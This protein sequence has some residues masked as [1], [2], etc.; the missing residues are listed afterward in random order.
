[1]ATLHT[2]TLTVTIDTPV[3]KEDAAAS[4]WPSRK[5]GTSGPLPRR[6]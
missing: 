1:M 6:T 3:V 2:H 4:S 5:D